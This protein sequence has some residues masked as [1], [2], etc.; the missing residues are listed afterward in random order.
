M[1]FFG[2]SPSAK[3]SF[4]SCSIPGMLPA[5]VAQVVTHCFFFRIWL[6]K[7]MWCFLGPTWAHLGCCKSFLGIPFFPSTFMICLCGGNANIFLIFTP[8]I[9][10]MNPFW[11]AYFSDG[12]V[13]PPT[14]FSFHMFNVCFRLRFIFLM[15]S[16]SQKTCVCWYHFRV[17]LT[18]ITIYLFFYLSIYLSF[19]LSFFFFFFFLF[20]SFFF[21]IY[22][23]I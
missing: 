9:G 1:R 7:M 19:F 2:S 11:R 12:L 14:S 13:Q 22:I 23:Y 10:K 21:Y 8:I 16:K 6:N 15:F 17:H 18:Y 20:L 4:N 5:R 3:V